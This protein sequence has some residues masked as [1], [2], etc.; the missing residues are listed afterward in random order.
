MGRERVRAT[1]LRGRFV[2]LPYE[3]ICSEQFRRLSHA[4]VRLLVLVA[5]GY[6]GRNN[7]KLVACRKSLR[8]H[9]WLSDDSTSRC[10]KQLTEAGLLVQTRMGARPNKAG[11]YALSWRPLDQTD[12]LDFDA[13]LWRPFVGT[14]LGPLIGPTMQ[15]IGP[16]GGQANAPSG[17]TVGAIRAESD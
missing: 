4:S 6:S 11:W 5:T 2:A 10:L 8:K 1:K 16:S 15:R 13:R 17:P 12:G 9:G 7:G 14:P 3:V